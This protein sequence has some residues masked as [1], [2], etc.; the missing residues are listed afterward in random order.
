MDVTEQELLR[1]AVGFADQVD[2]AFVV[3]LQV[4]TEA[5]AQDI[6][7]LAGEGDEFGEGGR[8]GGGILAGMREEGKAGLKIKITTK[9]TNGHKGY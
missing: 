5:G 2:H 1:L 3:N 6:A 8:H 9:D 7:C 4:L